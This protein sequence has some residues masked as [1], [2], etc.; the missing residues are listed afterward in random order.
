MFR[1]MPVH[2]ACYAEGRFFVWIENLQDQVS[3]RA[4]REHR[5]K[6]K[7]K[8]IIKG[9]T[10]NHQIFS[11]FSPRPLRSPESKANGRETKPLRSDFSQSPQR[12]QRE[13]QCLQG[14]RFVGR[15]S[16]D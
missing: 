12:T 2:F 5:E 1:L 9:S 3:R 14:I 6:P 11:R 8:A 4:R 15:I 7:T 16:A 10:K 13:K